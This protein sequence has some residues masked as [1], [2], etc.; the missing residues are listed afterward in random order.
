VRDGGHE[1]RTERFADREAELA[2]IVDPHH[3]GEQRGRIIGRAHVREVRFHGAHV[4]QACGLVFEGKPCDAHVAFG[5]AAGHQVEAGGERRRF[6]TA[7]HADFNTFAIGRAR[8]GVA[9]FRD[10]ARHAMRD[11]H[12]H[13]D[14]G[15]QSGERCGAHGRHGGDLRQ[16]RSYE[17]QRHRRDGADS[18]DLGGQASEHRRAFCCRRT[19]WQ[20]VLKAA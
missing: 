12:F 9:D 17:N 3:D 19:R 20:A 16:E 14:I 4:R 11:E 5:E 7:L 15:E 18:G 1:F 2:E 8:E 6:V 10:R 13:N